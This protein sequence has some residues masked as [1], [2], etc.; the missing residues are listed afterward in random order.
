MQ[1]T[2]KLAHLELRKRILK[3]LLEKIGTALIAFDK[4]IKEKTIEI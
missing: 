4:I 3:P 2:T 1:Q